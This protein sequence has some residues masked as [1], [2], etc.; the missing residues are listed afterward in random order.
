MKKSTVK[1]SSILAIS[2][3]AF[4]LTACGGPAK[5]REA[6]EENTV[7][8]E[9]D[10]VQE[11]VQ[12]N[13]EKYGDAE[14]GGY[15][16]PEE[17]AFTWETVEGGVVIT[18]YIGSDTAIIIPEQLGGGPVVQIAANAFKGTA[19]TGVEL[20]DSII[21]LEEGTFTFCVALNEVKFGASMREVGES[22]FEGCSALKLVECNEGLE[23]IG[24]RA[25][26][27]CASL[28]FVELPETLKILDRGAFVMS[29][30][31]SIVIPGSVERIGEQ[32]F[33]TCN[34]LKEV[35]IQ[36]GVT[37]IERKAFE[38]C[39]V[40]ERIEIPMSVEEIGHSAVWG[41]GTKTEAGA[42]TIYAPAGSAAEAA[43]E[44]NEVNFQTN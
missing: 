12:D 10:F 3:L 8:P 6:E 9:L 43:A 29:G 22:A 15:V 13:I 11:Q 16:T 37:A 5:D 24:R 2:L 20:A 25:F 38:Y 36:E 35:V 44:E 40:L 32:A 14:I 39:D 18:G 7:S 41:S 26:G 17:S 23:I 30:I 34:D 31:T 1:R 42:A 33:S 4:G 28:Q 27:T 21:T 19:V